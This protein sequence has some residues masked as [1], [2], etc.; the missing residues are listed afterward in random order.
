MRARHALI[1][2]VVKRRSG[3]VSGEEGCLSVPGLWEDVTRSD[4]VVVAGLDEEGRAV[5]LSVEGYLARAIQHEMDHLEGVLFVDRL[6][7]LKRQ[8]LRRA[9][10][11]LARGEVPE[12]HHPPARRRRTGRSV[13][14]RP[15]V[16][17]MGTP[18]FAV[19][20]LRAVARSC[21]VVAVVTQPD[22]GRGRGRELAPS[23]VAARRGGAGAA[24]REAG[25]HEGRRGAG[26]AG[27]AGARPVR[28]GRLR[29]HPDSR[30]CWRCRASA[31]STCTARCCP[32]TAA[33]RRC[34][35]RCGTAAPSPA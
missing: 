1:N 34:S 16:V 12:G 13:L 5:E 8:F 9:L 11:S 31:R 15:R 3:S 25:R 6:S 35:A 20:A 32:S 7:L 10:D 17:F 4:R 30:R 19:P 18:D 33:P 23:E 27:R 29:R 22:R 26:A 14:S 28:G 21:D 2:P 24:A